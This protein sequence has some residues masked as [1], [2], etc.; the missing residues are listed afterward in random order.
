[1]PKLNQVRCVLAVND[2]KK[3]AEFYREKLGFKLD[4]E[5]DRWFFLSRDNFKVMLGHCPNEVSASKVGDHSWFAYAY[6]EDIDGLHSE[7]K[8]NGV[9]IIQE[10]SEK[11]WGMREFCIETPDGHRIMFGQELEQKN[12]T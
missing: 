1:M 5:V 7:Y 10:I 8:R 12:V 4:T 9:K 11:P 6:I 3:S 2:Y